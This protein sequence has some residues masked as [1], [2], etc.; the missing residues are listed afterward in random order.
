[1]RG[2]VETRHAAK[3]RK[4]ERRVVARIEA[5]P[6]GLDIRYVVTLLDDPSPE[7][8]YARLCCARGQAE[9]LIKRHQTQLKSDR[10]SCRSPLADQI[11]LVL[12]TA[13]TLRPAPA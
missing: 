9:K 5:T 2:F 13:A 4:H 6:T 8:I 11:R 1:M 7:D 3:S 12:P 10:A